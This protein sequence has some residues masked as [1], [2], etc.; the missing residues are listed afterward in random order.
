MSGGYEGVGEEDKCVYLLTGAVYCKIK[1]ESKFYLT[2]DCSV[3]TDAWCPKF[4]LQ[5]KKIQNEM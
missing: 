4:S 5:S 1:E 2:A 3:K